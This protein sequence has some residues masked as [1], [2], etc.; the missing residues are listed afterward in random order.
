MDD[1]HPWQEPL[2]RNVDELF[3]ICDIANLVQRSG[4]NMF[5][6]ADKFAVGDTFFYTQPQSWCVVSIVVGVVG[7]TI[8][9]LDVGRRGMKFIKPILVYD[10]SPAWYAEC[11]VIRAKRDN[12]MLRS[13]HDQQQEKHRSRDAPSPVSA[14]KA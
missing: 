12:A 11:V 3:R 9:M 1:E 13:I 6:T 5:L 4:K 2:Q 10:I 7:N 8:Y 14:L